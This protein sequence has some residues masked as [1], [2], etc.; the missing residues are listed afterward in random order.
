ML[1]L[2]IWYDFAS[3]Y[4]YLAAM[5]VERLADQAGVTVRW[6]PFLLGPVFAA[7]GWTDSP[8]NLYPAKG[9]YMWLDLTRLCA[10]EHLPLALP[11]YRFP[12]NGLKA[13][14]IALLGQESGWAGAFTR[15]V[16]TANFGEARD[17]SDDAVLIDILE[18]LGLD[19]AMLSAAAST[20]ANKAKL[21]DQTAQA[22]ALGIFGAPSFIAGAE[23]FW[24]N[25][26]LEDA[27]RSIT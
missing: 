2:D 17:I 18:A 11:P 16:F 22:M 13:S 12:Q 15:A 14:R 9:R 24:G 19:A 5:R 10:R 21:K 26:R 3:S 27:L 25:D 8:F 20:P 1:R 23:L 7:Q 4:S 6:R